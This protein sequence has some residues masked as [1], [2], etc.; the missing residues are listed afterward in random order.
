MISEAF[1]EEF[2]EVLGENFQYT[3]KVLQELKKNNIVALTGKYKGN[4]YQPQAIRNVF[5]GL[6]KNVDIEIAIKEVFETE[7]A[8]LQKL[9][10]YKP[11]L[12]IRE[13]PNH[14]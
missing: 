2:K 8:K 3:P 5:L 9:E 1:R 14:N 13:I 10:A 12:I 4:P 7:K 6:R 11:K